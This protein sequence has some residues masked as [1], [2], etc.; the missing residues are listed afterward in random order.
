MSE[1]TNSRFRAGAD[2]SVC[3]APGMARRDLSGLASLAGQLPGLVADER[4]LG[5]VG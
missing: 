1:K 5:A 4:H 2:M 3:L